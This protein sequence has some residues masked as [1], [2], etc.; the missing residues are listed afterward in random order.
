M[1]TKKNQFMIYFEPLMKEKLKIIADE[2]CRSMNAE[3]LM[4]IK[5]HIRAYESEN[6]EIKV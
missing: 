3:I 4:L 5:K 6:G 1:P 2:N